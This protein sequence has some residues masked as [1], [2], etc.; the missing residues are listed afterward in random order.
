M[1][2]SRQRNLV[3]LAAYLVAL[4]ALV[5]SLLVSLYNLDLLTRT[6]DDVDRA[7]RAR[8][9]LDDYVDAITD[10]ETGQRGYLL[11][12][13]ASYLEPYHTG[14]FQ[15]ANEE[16]EL[17]A[18]HAFLGLA[19]DDPDLQALIAS[20]AAKRQ[21]MART[22]DVFDEL[23]G[24]A[25]MD[26][27]VTDLG[28]KLMG[29]IKVR[30]R[31]LKE[32]VA[33]RYAELRSQSE[34]ARRFATVSTLVTGFLTI[35]MLSLAFFAADRQDLLRRVAQARAEAY[36]R[37]LT[38]LADVGLQLNRARDRPSLLGMASTE[39]RRLLSVEVAAAVVREPES[40]SA[41]SVGTRARALSDWRPE[42]EPLQVGLRAE[43]EGGFSAEIVDRE[44]NLVLRE[45]SDLQ[46]AVAIPL[47]NRKGEV[48]GH[49]VAAEPVGEG[50]DAVAQLSLVQLAQFMSVAWENVL[51]LEELQQAATERESF[52][53]MLGH[54]LRNP[55]NA[56]S[57]AAQVLAM[58]IPADDPLAELVSMLR[59]QS[60]FMRELVDDLLDVAR[61]ERGTIE[62]DRRP[63]DV[64][65]LVR[66]VADD[67]RTGRD[68]PAA[69]EVEIPPR[70][71]FVLGDPP[72]IAQCVTNLLDNAVK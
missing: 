31:A 16:P 50:M 35:L 19:S 53:N 72:R 58:R 29:D 6:A 45:P 12:G 1:I 9:V 43:A 44:G 46:T 38:E 64:A 60:S 33:L 68:L 55:L 49:L 14:L 34:K 11:T 48:F 42:D 10:A 2:L 62:L 24:K 25:A 28:L 8:F 61:L 56:I 69:L 63:V 26:L 71:K 4:V 41:V 13:D 22:I 20:T 54:E 65:H 32:R 15:L 7:D 18:S 30:Q 47:F 17:V 70:R 21:E 67:F 5:L 39:L 23:G 51:L 57:G 66:R 27:V 37:R 59:R 52:M 3:S 40:A 36:S